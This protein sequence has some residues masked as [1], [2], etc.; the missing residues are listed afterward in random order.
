MGQNSRH[1]LLGRNPCPPQ[2]PSVDPSLPLFSL[3]H[4]SASHH[5]AGARGRRAPGAPGRGAGD[6]GVPGPGLPAHPHEL[7]Q[8]RPAPPALPAHPPPRLRPRPP[9]RQR[10]D[11]LT[12][13]PRSRPLL[14]SLWET[15]RGRGDLCTEPPSL[16]SPPLLEGL[17]ISRVQLA[18]AGVFTC[19]AASPAGVADRNFTL[20]V[21]GTE[22]G[23]LGWPWPWV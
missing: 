20:Q 12:W 2:S 13:A 10:L 6:H 17:R 18:D 19:V 5:R 4:P 3:S 22:R 23:A 8:G 15:E 16:S 14:A 11:L 21:H 7:A 1:L 9:V